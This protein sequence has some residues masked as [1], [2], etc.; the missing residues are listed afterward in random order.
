[1]GTGSERARRAAQYATDV[2]DALRWRWG[3]VHMEV[4]WVE[5]P[6][7]SGTEGRGPVLIEANCGR[8]NGEEFKTIAEVMY[9][10]SMHDAQRVALFG[11]EEAWVYSATRCCC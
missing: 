2:L 9:G 10:V 4:M 11:D 5:Q 3:P 7:P 1:M 6:S 8:L